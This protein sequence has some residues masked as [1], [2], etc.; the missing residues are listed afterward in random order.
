MGGALGQLGKL[1]GCRVAGVVGASHQIDAVWS[2][3]TDATIDK[4]A[5]LWR[6]R[7]RLIEPWSPG[8]RWV[9][10]S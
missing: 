5:T 9:S 3:G 2:L 6:N 10:W 4:S 7:P 8:Q 1:A